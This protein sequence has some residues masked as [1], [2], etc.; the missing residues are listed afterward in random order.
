MQT[1]RW[2]GA[3]IAAS[4]FFIPPCK[5]EKEDQSK[6]RLISGSVSGEVEIKKN[7]KARRLP[8][9][10]L[11]TPAAIDLSSPAAQLRVALNSRHHQ[12]PIPPSFAYTREDRGPAAV[13]ALAASPRRRR[14]RRRRKGSLILPWYYGHGAIA[15]PKHHLPCP[16]TRLSRMHARTHARAHP[17]SW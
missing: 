10:S 1:P 8:F 15:F 6:E 16:K 2:V 9:F 17:E 11:L 3:S 5:T 7:P 12:C 13:T 4:L 14:R